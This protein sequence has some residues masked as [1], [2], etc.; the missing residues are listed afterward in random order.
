MHAAALVGRSAATG[1]IAS[2]CGLQLLELF[3][4][5][6]ELSLA[7]GVFAGLAVFGDSGFGVGLLAASG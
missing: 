7:F 1:R 5:A 6:L 4:V 3:N 2:G